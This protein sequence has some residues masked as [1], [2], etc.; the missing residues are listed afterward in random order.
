MEGSRKGVRRPSHLRLYGLIA[1]MV[2]FW[3]MNFTIG[4]FALREFHPV[5]LSGL[6]TGLAALFIAPI[7]LWS[8]RHPPAAG[9]SHGENLRRD[10][11]VLLLLGVVGVA[12]NQVFF[13]YGLSRTSVAHSALIMGMTPILVLLLAGRAGQESIGIRKVAGMAVAV[14]GVAAINAAPSKGGQATPAGD[15][16]IF[17]ASAAFAVFTVVGKQVTA[18]HGS[19]TVNTV[20]YL[21]GAAAMAPLTLSLAGA[22][23]FETVTARGWLSL[24]YM[25]LFPS[26]IC[27]LIYYYALTHIPASRLSAFSY[28][29]PLLA[30]ILALVLLGEHISGGLAAGG[31]LVLAG[32]YITERG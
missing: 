12:L 17:L 6:R 28:F 21:G 15:F 14:A 25:A 31:A 29:Q 7:Y 2:L 19:I 11:R 24:L 20:A 32:V 8:L 5:L 13:V 3:S 27:Y 30:T 18:R 23:P 4:K 26:M 1:L 9:G 16:F 22:F 10:W